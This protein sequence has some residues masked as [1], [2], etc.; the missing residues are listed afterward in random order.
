M[1]R[2]PS[3]FCLLLLLP[4]APA[5]EILSASRRGSRCRASCLPVLAVCLL[6]L[7]SAICHADAPAGRPEPRTWASDDGFVEVQFGGTLELEYYRVGEES[8][9]FLRT[10]EDSFI[11][12]RLTWLLDTFIGDHLYLFVKARADRG[13]DPGDTPGEARLDEY[14]ARY[15]LPGEG[16]SVSA[17]VGKFATPVGNFVPRHDPLQAGLIR[18]PMMYDHPLGIVHVRP[19]PSNAAQIARRD[20][21][22][23]RETWSP[24]IWGPVYHSGGMLFAKAG[25][26]EARFAATNAVPSSEP[27]EWDAQGGDWRK[28]TFSGRLGAEPIHG[29]KTGVSAAHGPYL[30]RTA[31]DTLRRD[32]ELDDFNQTL[33]GIDLE[34]RRGR[35]ALFAEAY[36]SRWEVPYVSDDLWGYGYYLEGKFTV[37]PRFFV[38]ARWGQMTFSDLR[39]AARRNVEWER[40]AFRIEWGGGYFFREDV[41]F[42]IQYEV[43]GNTGAFDPRDDML[44]VSLTLAF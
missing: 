39:N 8:P 40:D 4:A 1:N 34:F 35:L 24:M 17:Q 31:E 44:T 36:A 19:T 28:V 43:N 22:A 12:P 29:I 25:I 23:N 32:D 18:P 33:T 7:P 37:V 10:N 26:F 27:V 20:K 38:A 14:F 5:P 11:H 2:R 42:R 6:F 15:T 13:F 21:P 9:G 3:A 16:W 41:L 30:D